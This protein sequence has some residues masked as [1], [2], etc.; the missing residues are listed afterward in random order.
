MKIPALFITTIFFTSFVGCLDDDTEICELELI[1]QEGEYGYCEFILFQDEVK[2][3]WDYEHKDGT[4]N[5]DIYIV[6]EPNYLEYHNDDPFVTV[7]Q[8]SKENVK[9]TSLSKTEIK[10]NKDMDYYI[11]V[12]HTT[13][14]KAQPNPGDAVWFKIVLNIAKA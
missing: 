13:T 7:S 2:V 6:D 1:A 4:S 12:D 10:L 8:L 11:I 5:V 9:T 14:G 3:W